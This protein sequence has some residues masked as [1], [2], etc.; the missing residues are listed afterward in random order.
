MNNEDF[1]KS[2]NCD[3]FLHVVDS[4][5]FLTLIAASFHHLRRYVSIQ[6]VKH[7]HV[8]CVSDSTSGNTYAKIHE[9]VE[10]KTFVV[11]VLAF[12]LAAQLSLEQ[13]S[14]Y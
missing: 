11:A 5:A 3:V 7:I 14:D 4:L 10:G 8:A 2:K 1:R 12:N 9:I 6:T 13:I